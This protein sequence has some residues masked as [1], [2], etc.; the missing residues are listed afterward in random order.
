[1]YK[2][3][4]QPRT[5]E[6]TE[7]ARDWQNPRL[8]IELRTANL[9]L[10]PFGSRLWRFDPEVLKA[11]ARKRT[12]L[13][14]FGDLAPLDEPLEL[15]CRGVNEVTEF[16]P[17][18]RLSMYSTI[19]SA[20]SNRLRLEDL[21]KRRP[22][23]FEQPVE[24]PIVVAGL[25]RSGT[26]FLQ[27]LMAED[28]G[29]RFI[30]FWEMVNPLPFGD[31]AEPVPDPDPRIAAGARIIRYMH[32]SSPEMVKMHEMDNEAAEEELGILAMG[33]CSMQ[34]EATA[35][36]LPDYMKWY[37]GTDHTAGYAYLRRVLQAMAWIR[38]TG[39]RWLLKSPQHMEQFKPLTAAFPDATVVQTHRDPVR[40]VLSTGSLLAYS[41]R[42][43][44]AHPNPHLVGRQAVI[45][46]ER[47]LRGAVRDR[48]PADDRFVD[49]KFAELNA[50]PIG[51]VR[52]IYDRAGAELTPEAERRL[53]EWLPKNA[54]GKHGEHVYTAADLGLDPDE[55]RER[56]AFYYEH[57]DVP[58]E[59]L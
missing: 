13:T 19:L 28:P 1:M 54:R 51:T 58:H 47:L 42:Q 34:F 8:P 45:M 24:G 46:T 26:S 40:S 55:L 7:R 21:A 2:G 56:F 14:D 16:H 5:E 32:R 57:F 31:A 15:L 18:G 53:K 17:F 49:V 38:P 44:Y 6:L 48:D 36:M 39:R 9:V 12:G 27:R 22:E 30:P 25:V 11:K 35:P 4:P 3:V 50:D 23:A 29:L 20:L 33:F 59:S 37:T 52:R 43:A 41:Y 10:R